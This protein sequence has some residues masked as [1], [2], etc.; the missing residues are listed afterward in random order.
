M[1]PLM[2]LD[3][4][5]LY[6]RAFYGVPDTMTAPDGTPVNAV[7]GLLDMIARL[8][9]ARHPARLVA[10]MDADWRPAFRVALIP[11]YKAHRANPDG[12]EEAPAALTA[13]IP[14]IEEVLAAAGVATA[15]APGYEADDVIGTLATKAAAAGSDV[16]IVTADK[17]MLQLVGPHVR[18]FHTGKEIF[19]DESGVEA[20]FGVRPGQV[21]DVL[22][23]MGDSV[24]NVPGV[25]GVGQVTAKKWIS[26]YG[27]L[28]KLLEK[29]DEIPGKMGESLRQ[30]REDA[31]LSRRLAGIPTDLP[32]PFEPETLKRSEPD[33][34][35]L[36]AI[37]SELEFSS[38]AAEIQGEAAAPPAAPSRRLAAGEA[39]SMKADAALGISLLG[40]G[41]DVLL[42]VSDGGETQI[43][44]ESADRVAARWR[45][46]DRPGL[47][48]AA[49]DAKPLDTLLARQGAAVAA[50][51]FDVGLAQYV[52][53]CGVASAEIDA[54]A[55]A[56]MQAR[57]ISDKE[58]GVAGGALAPGYEI[59]TAD[60]WLSERAVVVRA[61]APVLAA[62]LARRPELERIYR[63]VERPLTPVLARMELAG[64]AVDVA[65][66]KEMS[67]RMDRDLRDLERR[68][69]A[70][71]GE[72][73][74]VNSPV[75][76]GQIL[77]EKLGYPV[78]KKTAKT[79]SSS[80]GVEV[81]SDLAER[82]FPLPK[83]VL[84]YREISKLKG[85]YV[86]ALPA[87]ADAHGRVHTSYRQ[88]VAAT[89]R[90]SSS[91]PNLQNIPIRT[92]AGRE[93]RRAFVAPPGHQLVVADYSQIELRILAHLSAD[94]NL[95]E[96]FERG[97]DIHRATAA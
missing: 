7:R 54:I 58:A 47:P 85:T 97:D 11:G 20:F 80:T 42:A 6:Y 25:P 45:S 73:F 10:C 5:S 72:E 65:F 63:E 89:G 46:L 48:V 52:L 53:A 70:E 17:D 40:G 71:A 31:L 18:V 38:L 27:S 55:F 44:E 57:L 94:R 81:L 36:K 34:E 87:L 78:L 86:D 23:L 83:L 16:V 15:A 96:A 37:F 90:L 29:M 41:A 4:A 22:A 61:L 49:A 56:R 77:F 13:Q 66:L 84:E 12:S 74:N 62:E 91:D 3:S 2:L 93:I 21:A 24:D 33:L 60:R 43:A 1:P 69:W 28:E 68:I 26:T 19:L 59:G 64:V 39:F 32:V 75:K 79:K 51:V 30:H 14:V 76:L 95:I 50:D 92:A 67:Q 88:T 9:R 82:G 8:V 35:K